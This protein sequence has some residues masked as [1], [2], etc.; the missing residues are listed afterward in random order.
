M[1]HDLKLGEKSLVVREL[2][3][4]ELWEVLPVLVFPQ[5]KVDAK[6]RKD[7]LKYLITKKHSKNGQAAKEE[8]SKVLVCGSF[9]GNI[10]PP[11]LNINVIH[12]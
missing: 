5:A 9:Y 3:F 8:V 4:V 2:T 6:T 1:L 12:A 10:M 7:L 11:D